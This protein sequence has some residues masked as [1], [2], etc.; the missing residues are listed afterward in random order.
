M[1]QMEPDGQE[2]LKKAVE[3]YLAVRDSGARR[4][5]EANPIL[6]DLNVVADLV[7][8]AHRDARRARLYL[9]RAQILCGDRW[10]DGPQMSARLLASYVALEESPGDPSLLAEA[11][12]A[13]R[14]FVDADLRPVAHAALL[15]DLLWVASLLL[16]ELYAATSQR[17][18]LNE[19]LTMQKAAVGAAPAGSDARIGQ[20]DNLATLLGE[21]YAATGDVSLLDEALSILRSVVDLPADPALVAR[22]QSTLAARLLDL[23]DS[24]SRPELLDEAIATQRAATKTAVAQ[25]DHDLPA[26]IHNLAMVLSKGY[27]T[28]GRLELLN[29]AVDLQRRAVEATPASD[30]QRASRLNNLAGHLADLYEATRRPELLEEAVSIQ[31]AAVKATSEGSVEYPLHLNSLANHLATLYEVTADARLLNDAIEWQQEALGVTDPDDPAFAGHLNNLALHQAQLYFAT[32]DE[33]HLHEAVIRARASVGATPTT[34]IEHH[35]RLNNLAGHLAVLYDATGRVELIEEATTHQREVVRRVPADSPERPGY[36][37][38]LANLLATLYRATGRSGLLS[39]ASDLMKWVRPDTPIDKV[40]LALTRSRLA[41]LDG[42]YTRAVHELTEA[43]AAFEEELARLSDTPRHRR[44]LAQ[45]GDGLI[46][47][48]MTCY[49]RAHNPEGAIATAERG[50]LWLPAPDDSPL[51]L[52]ET[53]VTVAW[54]APGQWETVV[55]T[56]T[57]QQS[58][59]SKVVEITRQEIR[60]AVVDALNAARSGDDERCSRTVDALCTLA[61]RVTDVLPASRRLLI[62]P[63]GVAAML[64]FAASSDRRGGRLIDHTTVSMAPSLAWARSASRTRHRGTNIGVFH[65]GPSDRLL[66]VGQDRRTFQLEVGGQVLDSPNADVVVAHFEA[67][68]PIAHFSCHGSYDQFTPIESSLLLETKLSIRAITDHGVAP[69]LV[70]LSACETAVPDFRASEQLISFPTAFLLGGAAH[71]LASLW[72]V[73]D[74]D[75]IEVNRVCYQE[76][77]QGAHPAEALRTAVLSLRAEHPFRWGLFSHHGSP[78]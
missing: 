28:Y 53:P 55:I 68:T 56:T 2:T 17:E 7:D 36:V 29:E 63:I 30:P 31:T 44:D 14:P 6:F 49:V 19:A 57:D 61:G 73:I 71:V 22:R 15:P 25:P 75:A 12:A 46:G 43:R 74:E 42:D 27:E 45:Q 9:A 62:V 77:A 76:L 72:S 65:P 3:G 21:A 54:V 37:G 5:A 23:Y 48:L 50:R 78:W 40:N 18:R 8:S 69:W 70:N 35:R 26:Q 58:Y 32:S 20:L 64:P 34:H 13:T 66:D 33:T 52:T 1:Q 4:F 24:S 38:N 51:T 59:A 39:E 47:D 67:D 11:T 41:R 10:R 60:S 16:I